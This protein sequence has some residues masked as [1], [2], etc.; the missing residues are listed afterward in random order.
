MKYKCNDSLHLFTNTKNITK[1]EKIIC[2]SFID[3]C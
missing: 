3:S 2:N 1:N